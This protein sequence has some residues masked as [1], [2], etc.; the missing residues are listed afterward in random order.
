M[1]A[2]HALF[3]AEVHRVEG[4]DSLCLKQVNALFRCGLQFVADQL[5]CSWSSSLVA[6]PAVLRHQLPCE[7]T[8]VVQYCLD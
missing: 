8:T 7:L 1:H 6:A 5:L 3:K 4:M 2:L